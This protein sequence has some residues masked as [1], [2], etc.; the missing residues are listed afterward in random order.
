MEL[1]K[2]TMAASQIANLIDDKREHANIDSDGTDLDHRSLTPTP[3]DALNQSQAL[4][5]DSYD[6]DRSST[7]T[8]DAL[9]PPYSHNAADSPS[10]PTQRSPNADG[11][12]PTSL[13]QRKSSLSPD[14]TSADLSGVRVRTKGNDLKSGFPYHPRLFDLRVRPDNW[15]QFSDQ[16]INATKLTRGDHAKVWAAAGGVAL[17]GRVLTSAWVGKYAICHIG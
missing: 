15:Q 12:S 5:V 7:T 16:V 9:P 6:K 11:R 8:K 14:S 1:G 13:H 4:A 3:Q 10:S 17:T 2:T